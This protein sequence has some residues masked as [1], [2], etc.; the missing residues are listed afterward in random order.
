MVKMRSMDQDPKSFD[1]KGNCI[2]FEKLLKFN[3]FLNLAI[4]DVQDN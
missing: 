1:C 3:T 4:I 2:S